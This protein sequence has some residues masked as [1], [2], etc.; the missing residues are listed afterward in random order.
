MAR[1]REAEGDLDGALELVDAAD[2]VY[3]GDYSPNVRPVPAVRARLRLRRA[4]LSSAEAW[5]RARGLSAADELSYLHEYEHVTLAR[6]LLARHHEDHGGD[7]LDEATALLERLLAAAEAGDR[8]GSVLEL[9]ILLAL[10]RQAGGDR[11][12]ALVVLGRAV[13]LGQA[14]GYVRVFAD[15]GPPMAALLKALLRRHPGDPCVGYVRRL[16]AAATRG[17]PRPVAARAGLLEP[18]SDRELDVLRLLA[19]ELGGP[20]IARELH[21]ALSTV[22]THTKSIYL[23]LGVS[24][25]LAAVRRATELDL[26][27]RGSA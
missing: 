26:V 16:L 18:L 8:D 22:R 25:R 19:T 6:L 21:V 5:A 10:A 24:G 27:R 2:R 17:E 4:E 20:E 7:A 15:E 23:K 1:L 14:E 12:A 13:T 11:S 3:N 9:L